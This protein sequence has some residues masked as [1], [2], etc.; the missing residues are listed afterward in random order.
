[1]QKGGG[2]GEKNATWW[3]TTINP[4]SFFCRGEFEFALS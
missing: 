1:M 2:A 3:V 4:R